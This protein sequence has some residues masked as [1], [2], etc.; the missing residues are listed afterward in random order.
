MQLEDVCAP[1]VSKLY[2]AG[3]GGSADS[4]DDLGDHDEL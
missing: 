4:E 3:G 1:V 2:G